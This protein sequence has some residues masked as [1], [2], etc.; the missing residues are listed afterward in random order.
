MII[1]VKPETVYAKDNNIKGIGSVNLSAPGQKPIRDVMALLALIIIDLFAVTLSFLLAYLIRNYLL[2]ELFPSLITDKLLAQTFELFW[3]YPLTFIVIFGYEK[4][5]QKRLPFWIEAQWVLKAGTISLFLTIVLLY[6]VRI[7]DEIS[8]SL[9]LL[10]WVFAMLALPVF[11]YYGKKLLLKL[12]IW[13]KPIIIIGNSETIT[14]IHGALQRE[15]TMGYQMVGYIN[16]A[17]QPELNQIESNARLPLPCLGRISDAAAIVRDCNVD[18][19]II[20]DSGLT[21][22]ELVELTNLLQPLVNN[23]ILVPDLFGVSMSGLE[24]AYF[25]EEQAVLLQIK[26]RMRSW[27]NRAIKRIFD[28]LVGTL[29]SLL[30]L[31]PVIL[32]SMAIK[33]DSPGPVFYVSERIGQ[34]GRLFPCYKF[35]TMYLN[36]DTILEQFLKENPQGRQ[37]WQQFKKLITFD[38]RV[39]RVGR[40][41]RRFSL[42]EL[43]QLINVL[44]GEMTLVGPRPYLPREK[45]EM[46]SY[47]YDIL[48]GKPGLTG[49]W[50][51]S[52][53]NRISFNNRLK[54]D[55]WYMK[56]WS[57]WLDLIL[58]FKTARVVLR[59]DGAY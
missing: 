23:I 31:P 11:R 4:L 52:G 5:Y 20:T 24:A 22:T 59:R 37:E 51:V 21:S 18:D 42:D 7:G 50:Q 26:N 36:S 14:L 19:L 3:W 38:P 16:I 28:L 25:F 49:L 15:T 35:R 43:P 54:L 13:T 17:G 10:T 44:R 46:K 45:E 53:R 8:R 34:G 33:L 32:I 41:L 30:A 2:V 56:N 57:L 27:L 47:S 6:L 1:I 9:V 12:N 58:L 39:T 40:I 48:V 55:S 29:F